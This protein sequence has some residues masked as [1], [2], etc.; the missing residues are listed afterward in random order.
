MNKNE[1]LEVLISKDNLKKR[2]R[3]LADT[4]TK[5]YKG[6]KPIF[7]S[8][9]KGSGFFLTDL[10]RGMKLDLTIDYMA[11]SS[12]GKGTESSGNVRIL[13]DLSEPV[14]GKDVIIVEDIIDT[15]YTLKAIK[16]MLEARKA[17]SV[18]ICVLLD[19]PERR[20]VNIPIDY[21]G[22]TIPDLFVVGYGIDYAERYRSLPYIAVLKVN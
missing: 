5:D 17:N 7:V 9:L 15:G 3:E 21:V 16:E 11:A 8:I 22:F 12:Y 14:E 4:I 6:K 13:K 18:K 19:K 2:I 1:K 20:K 10:V